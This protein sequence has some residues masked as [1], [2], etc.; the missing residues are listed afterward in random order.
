MNCVHLNMYIHIWYTKCVM[1]DGGYPF[2]FRYRS[3]LTPPHR[4]SRFSHSFSHAAWPPLAFVALCLV[5]LQVHIIHSG[6]M[7]TIRRKRRKKF[8]SQVSFSLVV[9]TFIL[10]SSFLLQFSIILQY[11]LHYTL[12]NQTKLSFRTNS[13]T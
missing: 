7:F 1:R 13:T 11:L 5:R 3:S 8:I 10:F 9:M 12:K 2:S 6:L 4:V